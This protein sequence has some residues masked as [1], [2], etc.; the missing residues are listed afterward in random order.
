MSEYFNGS[1]KNRYFESSQTAIVDGK[2]QTSTP[3]GRYQKA[4]RELGR[5]FSKYK[6]SETKV[7]KKTYVLKSN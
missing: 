5:D 6:K 4:D 2:S 7:I 3:T 1:T